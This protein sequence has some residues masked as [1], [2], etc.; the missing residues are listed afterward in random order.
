MSD[1]ATMGEFKFMADM[2]KTAKALSVQDQFAAFKAS[3]DKN[4]FPVPKVVAAKLA[5]VT[6]ARIGG[7]IKEG[8]LDVIELDG[9]S[10]VTENSLVA[11]MRSERKAGRPSKYVQAAEKR[12]PF[13]ASV[14]LVA[15]MMK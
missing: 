4:G 5:D 1:T 15:G 7:L 2:P 9:H 10:F 8:K 12:G 13:L 6:R 14:G 11:Y 3:I